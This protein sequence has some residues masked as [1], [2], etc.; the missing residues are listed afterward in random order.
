MKTTTK[1]DIIDII[2]KNGMAKPSE[3]VEKLK[4]TKAAIHRHLLKLVEEGVIQKHGS[5]PKV[6]YTL[7]EEKVEALD[8][9]L[10]SE[11]DRRFL[12]LEYLYIDPSGSILKGL[13]GF[14][15]WLKRIK[16]EKELLPLAKEFKKIRTKASSHKG[17]DG[18][19]EASF[20]FKEVFPEC[21]LNEVYYIDFFALPKFGKTL[22]GNLLL[23]SKQSQNREKIVE[24]AKLSQFY[25]EKIIKK[26][27]INA[28]GIIPHS[29]PRKI[30][31]LKV[32]G[33]T[34]NIDLPGI[35]ILK[36]YSGEI[37]I[38]QKSL[39]KLAER[40]E[41]ARNTI[42]LNSG[43]IKYKNILLIDDA[44][45]SGSTLNETARKIKKIDKKINVF[46][47]AITGS[48]KGFE[49]MKEV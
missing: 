42:F 35:E 1:Q 21:F 20:K 12:D 17:A 29:I 14:C 37:L 32:F 13:E 49:V 3:L 47:F 28:I 9:S 8:T 16:K 39:S 33:E 45:G 41:N 7:K 2:E 43:D 24:L 44:I 31:F 30:P 22:L 11:E 40:V 26:N 4:I 46:G 5:P 10:V 15:A 25:L 6:F 23:H 34:I 19:I 48:Y 27:K 36:A 18:L 38:A